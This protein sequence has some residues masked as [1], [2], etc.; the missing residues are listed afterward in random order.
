MEE[1]TVSLKES[2]ISWD[3]VSLGAPCPLTTVQFHLIQSLLYAKFA[4]KLKE[5]FYENIEYSKTV[6]KQTVFWNFRSHN[7][8]FLY[9]IMEKFWMLD[10]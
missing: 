4:C 10:Q 8:E 3:L 5:I 6:D 9:S 7:K 2:I 1:G